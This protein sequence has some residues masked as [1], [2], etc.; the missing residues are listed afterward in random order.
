MLGMSM[1]LKAI[2][3]RSSDSS[4]VAKFEDALDGE[5]IKYRVFLFIAGR[6]TRETTLCWPARQCAACLPLQCR[7]IVPVAGSRLSVTT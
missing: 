4:F 1:I 5:Y 2:G 3:E 7:A 6:F